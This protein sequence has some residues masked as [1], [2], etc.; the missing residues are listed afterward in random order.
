MVTVMGVQAAT[1]NLKQGAGRH[2]GT[3]QPALFTR[4][5]VGCIAGF[6]QFLLQFRQDN[7]ASAK[8]PM[9]MPMPTPPG[10]HGNKS[11]LHRHQLAAGSFVTTCIGTQ[12]SAQALHQAVHA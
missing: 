4:L 12:S 2:L 9:P 7:C 6:L 10:L 3:P 5:G 11:L 8:K 1:R